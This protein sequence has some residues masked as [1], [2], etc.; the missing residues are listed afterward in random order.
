VYAAT[1][2]G[3]MANVLEAFG[4][5]RLEQIREDL[6][7]ELEE[8]CHWKVL[9]PHFPCMAV[10]VGPHSVEVPPSWPGSG[11]VDAVVVALDL[12]HA[13]VRPMVLMG[14][15][16]RYC[17]APPPTNVTV[18]SVSLRIPLAYLNVHAGAAGI[19]QCHISEVTRG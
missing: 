15:P 4:L 8:A 6:R 7:R 11:R 3:S 10:R 12:D 16:D 2:E 1:L 19:R 13:R 14:T 5:L 9:A 17:P 18:T